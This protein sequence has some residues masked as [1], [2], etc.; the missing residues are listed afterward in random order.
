MQNTYGAKIYR[1]SMNRFA[2]KIEDHSSE[3]DPAPWV[4]YQED[5]YMGRDGVMYLVVE[6]PLVVDVL[7]T[8]V[9]LDPHFGT[10]VPPTTQPGLRLVN[11][12]WTKRVPIDDPVKAMYKRDDAGTSF[13]YVH[14]N[15]NKTGCDCLKISMSHCW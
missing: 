13:Y 3:F 2:V 1:D 7:G 10:E 8:I 12:L 11:S 15:P 5:R 9:P 4:N 6:N 14:D